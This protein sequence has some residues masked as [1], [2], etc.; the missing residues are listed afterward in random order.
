MQLFAFK[1][2]PTHTLNNTENQ[3]SSFKKEENLIPSPNFKHEY[4]KITLSFLLLGNL[5]S[6]SL[7]FLTEKLNPCSLPP[8]QLPLP[9]S[10]FLSKSDFSPGPVHRMVPLLS[11]KRRRRGQKACYYSERK[12]EKMDSY[13]DEIQKYE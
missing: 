10:S 9:P 1:N 7:P 8:E 3:R 11:R 6:C 5:Q 2:N 13:G 12:E 4:A